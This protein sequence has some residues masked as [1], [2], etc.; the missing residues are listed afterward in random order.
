MVTCGLYL[1]KNLRADGKFLSPLEFG[2][3]PVKECP[4]PF[5]VVFGSETDVVGKALK[6]YLLLKAVMNPPP[7]GLLYQLNSH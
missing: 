6:F 1:R 4:D 7:D 5:L 2:R 3:S